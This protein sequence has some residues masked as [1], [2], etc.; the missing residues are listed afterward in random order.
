MPGQLHLKHSC[1]LPSH[2]LPKFQQQA[3]VQSVFNP[4]PASTSQQLIKMSCSRQAGVSQ[5]HSCIPHQLLD[6]FSFQ[7]FQAMLLLRKHLEEVNL[8]LP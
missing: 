2:S 4:S 5:Q 8:S 1:I 6:C 3:L 7:G